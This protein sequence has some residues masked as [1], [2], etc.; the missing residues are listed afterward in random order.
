MSTES[1]DSEL[2]KR[3]AV[4]RLLVLDVDG[5]LTDGR[6]T[7]SA[8]NVEVKSFHVRDGS[9]VVYWQTVGGKTAIISGRTS[10][11][12]DGRAAELGISLVLQGA[13]DK[14][15]ALQN[16]LRQTGV[17]AEQVCAIGDDLPDLPML[18]GAGLSVAVADACAEV[19]EA[20]HYVTRANGG[21]GAVREVVE[22]LMRSQGRWA[23]IV[24]SFR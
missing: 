4:I 13:K 11:V 15:A 5:V 1:A 9:A 10:K 6:I 16:V 3:A 24:D 18:R 22:L 19:Q 12:V 14:R 2:M 8:E 17:F 21:C 23:T 20:A 7:Y